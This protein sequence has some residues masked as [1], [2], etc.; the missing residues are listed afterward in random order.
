MVARRGN[1]NPPR[2]RRTPVPFV[3]QGSGEGVLMATV[4]IMLDTEEW[5]VYTLGHGV[6]RTALQ[7]FRYP[8]H[9]GSHCRGV[10]PLPSLPYVLRK[11]RMEK[12]GRGLERDELTGSAS[13][14]G[15][16]RPYSPASSPT[17]RQ[18]PSEKAERDG[19]SLAHDRPC[20]GS[21]SRHC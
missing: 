5:F 2:R 14:D 3:E 17:A 10:Q 1:D 11:D 7:H 4:K 8:T 15:A 6:L 16:G 20:W 9:P 18:Q 13:Q 21:H 19:S 12:T